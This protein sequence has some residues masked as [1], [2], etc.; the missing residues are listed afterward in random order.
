MRFFVFTALFILHTSCFIFR[1]APPA[2]AQ[3]STGLSAI[4]PR[5]EILAV[6]GE[7]ISRV[8]KVRNDSNTIRDITV[9]ATNFIVTNDVGTP[10]AFSDSPHPSRWAASD[11][12]QISPSSFTLA[13]GQIK[14]LTLSVVT[15]TDALP[16]GHYVMVLHS[17]STS[18]T[19]KTSAAVQLNVGTLVYLTVPGAITQNARI[20]YFNAP[21]FSEFGPISF[22]T[23]IK[24]LSDIHLAPAGTI[25]VTNWLKGNTVIL[26][27]TKT[28][29]FPDT[30][31]EF[32]NTLDR[33]WLFGR[34]RADLLAHYG[35]AGG[36]LTVTIFFWVIPWR[37]FLLIFMVILFFSLI[38]IYLRRHPRFS[39]QKEIEKLEEKYL[40][41]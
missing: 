30:S 38:H 35:T 21:S 41:Q 23:S 36:L 28:N 17:P 4:P 19:S 40:D 37:L 32:T 18:A 10:I 39:P 29:I 13:P 1:N 5:L 16:G 11:W 15:P 20:N 34:Y 25:T 6:P 33:K 26:P 9:S 8:I 3:S 12:I 31:R 24:N 27:L 2:F 14:P 22:V 7:T